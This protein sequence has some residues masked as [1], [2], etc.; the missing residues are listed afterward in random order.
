MTLEQCDNAAKDMLFSLGTDYKGMS[1]GSGLAILA[2]MAGRVLA[3]CPT[4]ERV[5]VFERFI[6]ALKDVVTSLEQAS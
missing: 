2:I 3:Q 4:D 6:N 1:N 5:I